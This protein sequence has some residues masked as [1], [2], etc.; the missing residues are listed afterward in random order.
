MK[1]LVTLL[2]LMFFVFS[3]TMIIYASSITH[4]DV[5]ASPSDFYLVESKLVSPENATLVPI[6]TIR[7]VNNVYYIDFTYELVIKEGLALHSEVYELHF[8]DS[9]V[10]DEELREIFNFDI[11]QSTSNELNTLVSNGDYQSV[12]VNVRVSMN[13]PQSEELMQQLVNGQL[14]FEMYF[15]AMPQ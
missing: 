3:G 15:F 10:S 6:G 9:S 4:D 8:S 1:R 2:V 13:Q 14:T 12:I 7:S 11:T 5:L